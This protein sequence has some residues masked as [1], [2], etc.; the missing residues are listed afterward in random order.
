MFDKFKALSEGAAVK[1]RA[2]TS[3]TAGALESSKAQLGDAAANARAKGLALAGATAVKGRELAGATAEKGREL[4]GATAEKGSALVEQH[5]Q[6]IERV[7][8]DGL[9][10]V[11]AEKLKDDAMV[12]DVLERAYEALP[13]VVR[14]V[15]P[16]DRYLEIVIQ[17]KQP[18]LAKIEGA[19]NRRQERAQ[20]GAARNDPDA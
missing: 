18:L 1:A 16:R 14:L 13:T 11:S 4:A 2:L 10:S 19:R 5:W 7:T 15:L 9:L 12:K 6:T 8:V 3:R 17:K 20:A